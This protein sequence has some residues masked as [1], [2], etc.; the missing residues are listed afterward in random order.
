MNDDERRKT[1]LRWSIKAAKTK[2]RHL[3]ERGDAQEARLQVSCKLNKESQSQ[4]ETEEDART[5]RLQGPAVPGN[6]N[7]SV[8]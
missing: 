1:T 8:G 4:A 3:S 5:F 7:G 6:I 2:M